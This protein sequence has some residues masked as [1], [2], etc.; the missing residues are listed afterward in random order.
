[1]ADFRSLI[2]SIGDWGERAYIH[3]YR[4]GLASKLSD[5]LV[6]HLANFGI[7]QELMDITLES[8]TRYHE[9]QKGNGSNQEKKPQISRSNSSK[10][11]QSSSSKK[12]YHR[13]NKKGNNFQMYKDKPHSDLL[14]KENK[15]IVSKRR[16][17]LKMDYAPIVVAS[18]QSENASRGLKIGK[19]HQEASLASREKPEWG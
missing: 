18:T 7:L 3:V 5:Q 9:R 14:T 16:G 12:P 8:Y 1:M 19:G 15:F 6:S 17:G 4:R 11:P 2:S 13:K 10:P